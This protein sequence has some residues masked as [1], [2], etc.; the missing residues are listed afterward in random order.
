MPEFDQMLE[1]GK[2]AA[3]ALISGGVPFLLGGGIASW[4]RG[5]PPGDHDIDF[6]VKPAD[7]TR[8][9]QVLVDA[10]MRI[11]DPPENWLVKAF[12]G[13]V[14]V[15]LI[16]DPSGMPITDDV[17]DRTEE[18]PV[19]AVPMRVLRPEDIMV[20][21]ILALTEHH[22]DYEGLLEMARALREQVDWQEVRERTKETP[23]SR[24][25]FVLTE[26]LGILEAAPI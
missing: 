7:V 15:D 26:D 11:E 16:F 20:S 17:L 19:H 1:S 5:G 21:K 13:D 14:M 18:L 23:F 4:A 2:K 22:L 12:D 10:G 25:F 8:A 3:A 9:Q 6:F 24:A